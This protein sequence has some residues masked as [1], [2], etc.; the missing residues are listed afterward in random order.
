MPSL[1]ARISCSTLI[2]KQA[3]IL[4]EIKYIL[5]GSRV[6]QGIGFGQHGHNPQRTFFFSLFATPLL[7]G[8]LLTEVNCFSMGQML[9]ALVE[10]ALRSGQVGLQ[11]GDGPL[12]S[13]SCTGYW[14]LCTEAEAAYS[15]GEV[16]GTKLME[17]KLSDI[18]WHIC[19]FMCLRHWPGCSLIIIVLLQIMD[20]WAKLRWLG[21]YAVTVLAQ[22]FLATNRLSVAYW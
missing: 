6:D 9:W 10:L 7:A 17:D 3:F 21:K 19:K 18:S 14:L 5:N 15:A 22:N 1:S 4:G 2:N 12:H 16:C 13:G 20:K 8:P 11:G